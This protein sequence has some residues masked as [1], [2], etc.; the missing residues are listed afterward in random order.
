MSWLS[1]DSADRLKIEHTIS[2]PLGITR[3]SVAETPIQLEIRFSLESDQSVTVGDS[4]YRSG[5]VLW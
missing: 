1:A 5:L 2:A 3:N 4:A